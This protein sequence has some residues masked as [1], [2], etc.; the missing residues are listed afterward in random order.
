M[1][2]DV[3]RPEMTAREEASTVMDDAAD[4]AVNKVP[5]LFG[6]DGVGVGYGLITAVALCMLIERRLLNQQV[7]IGRQVGSL[8][9]QKHV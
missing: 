9:R 7:L 3:K 2:A 8:E 6:G 5:S 1:V 4:G